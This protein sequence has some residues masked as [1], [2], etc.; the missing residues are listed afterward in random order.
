MQEGRLL[1]L[2]KN[3]VERVRVLTVIAFLSESSIA[4]T[5]IQYTNA[6]G[7]LTHCRAVERLPK[8]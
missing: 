4:G 5:V 2:F 6:L 7:K 1:S 3:L 8:L